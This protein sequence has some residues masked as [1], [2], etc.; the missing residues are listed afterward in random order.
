MFSGPPI[1]PSTTFKYDGQ[2]YMLNASTLENL[3]V[4]GRG[5]HG[6]VQ[7]MRHVPSG[8]LMAVKVKLRLISERSVRETFCGCLRGDHLSGIDAHAST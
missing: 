5:A 4:L 8:S 1:E 6:F 7:K 3:S 2:E